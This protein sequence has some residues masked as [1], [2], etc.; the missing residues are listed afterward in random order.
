MGSGG[1]QL[2]GFG[3]GPSRPKNHVCNTA[4]VAYRI[5]ITKLFLLDHEAERSR[6]L[7]Q[8]N[9]RA[10]HC[11]GSVREWSCHYDNCVSTAL[12]ACVLAIRQG[13]SRYPKRSACPCSPLRLRPSAALPR[14][15]RKRQLNHL[16]IEIGTITARCFDSGYFRKLREARIGAT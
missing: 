10:K 5:P 2:R 13:F 4:T 11:V 9:V 15:T 6:S 3:G 16:G 12:L 14:D 7:F 8:F 1:M